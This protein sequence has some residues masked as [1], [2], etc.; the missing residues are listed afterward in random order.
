VIGQ[1]TISYNR[2]KKPLSD[3]H[4]ALAFCRRFLLIF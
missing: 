1:P 2:A 3:P 4:F